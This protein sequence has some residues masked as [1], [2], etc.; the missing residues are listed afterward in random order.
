[1]IR[2]HNI[3]NDTVITEEE[4]RD[5]YEEKVANGEA[6][7]YDNF[8]AYREACMIY[9][10]GSLEKIADDWEINRLRRAVAWDIISATEIDAQKVMDWMED[11]DVFGNW[12]AW[13][14]NHR[15]VDVEELIEC[16]EQ[17]LS[18]ED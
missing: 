6:D 2:Y 11:N 7:D 9:N 10:N 12:T 8:M 18:E 13:E 4:L 1:M 5:E 14:I 17:M 16:A 3:D 15:P